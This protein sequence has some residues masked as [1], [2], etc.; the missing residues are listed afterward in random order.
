T[1]IASIE[2]KSRKDSLKEEAA[3][4][5]AMQS[6]LLGNYNEAA[7]KFNAIV[8]EN[9]LN[10]EA[11]FQLAQI[12]YQLGELDLAQS[13]NEK[14]IEINPNYEWHYLL[15]GQ[16][17]AENGKIDEAADAYQ[18]LVEISP[19][20]I[21][22]Y[23]D[24]AMLLSEAD[25]PKEAIEVYNLIEER[26]GPNEETL[27]QKLPLY[28]K[29]NQL[30]QAINDI[31]LLIKEDPN[32]YRYYGYLGDIYDAQEQYDKA[33]EA[34]LKILEINPGNVLSYYTL[35][36]AYA[37]KEDTDNQRKILS[38]AMNSI[39]IDL[40][41]KVRII[42]PVIQQQ[43]SKEQSLDD[44]NLILDLFQILKDN[45]PDHPEVIG[46]ISETYQALGE[47][48]KALGYLKENALSADP[49]QELYIQFLFMLSENEHLDDLYYYAQ[50]GEKQFSEDPIFDFFSALSAFLNKDYEA[51]KAAYEN[52]LKKDF[53]N[54]ALRLQMLVGLGDVS[55]EL[56]AYDIADEAYEQALE[57]NPNNAT[58]LNNYAYYLSVRNIELS[59]AERMS[60]KSNL[61]EEN[62]AAFQDTYAWILYQKGEYEE[63]LNWMNKAM[64]SAK[65]NP[66]S[67]MLDHLGD[68]LLKLDRKPEA[69]KYWNKA[70]ELNQ[71]NQKISD[72]IRLNQ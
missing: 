3:F 50:K 18:K 23:F 19:N 20:D 47:T 51:S 6:K 17:K 40:E 60:K 22:L 1:T 49:N 37:K 27:V 7:L 25:K 14:A 2:K 28:Q 45:Y 36:E 54:E 72:K 34:Y 8:K 13:A 68:I 69:L 32:Q 57:I 48:E 62:N 56:K 61:L 59:R 33:I 11:H 46:L 52:G 44:N 12:H 24:W 41:D 9:P 16:I 65:G 67:E 66:S 43:L 35:A 5:D 71:D 31:Q 70:L 39:D 63:A 4:I 53:N 10:H 26:T 15:L 38:E 55:G 64:E 30:N 42:L 21:D 58:A 29:T